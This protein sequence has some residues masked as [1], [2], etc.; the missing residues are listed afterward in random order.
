MKY[1]KFAKLCWQAYNGDIMAGVQV[2]QILR[3]RL[4]A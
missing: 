2:V 1:L 4:G 3:E